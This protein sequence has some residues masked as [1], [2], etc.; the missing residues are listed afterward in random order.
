LIKHYS[1]GLFKLNDRVRRNARQI[2]SGASGSKLSM[3]FS[4]FGFSD[5]SKCVLLFHSPVK[6]LELN[7]TE[8]SFRIENIYVVAVSM[9]K[10]NIDSIIPLC[11]VVGPGRVSS[12]IPAFESIGKS[13]MDIL[14]SGRVIAF[15]MKSQS[16][17]L[18]FLSHEHLLALKDFANTGPSC[19]DISTWKPHDIGLNFDN[20]NLIVDDDEVSVWW[21]G[22]G[23]NFADLAIHLIGQSMPAIDIAATYHDKKRPK[24]QYSQTNYNSD[25][26]V[27]GTL[28]NAGNQLKMMFEITPRK[29]IILNIARYFLFNKVL[30]K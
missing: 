28:F 21:H 10:Y 6:T 13:F 20:Q 24:K 14:D 8:K 1:A 9:E 2:F 12:L 25:L 26:N 27:A 30:M 19:Y 16:L 11:T 22:Y 7:E 23:T 15:N 3:I 4:A 18:L 5:E 17:G 29:T